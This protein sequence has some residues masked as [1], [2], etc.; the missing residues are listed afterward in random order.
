[1]ESTVLANAGIWKLL[2]RLN[3]QLTMRVGKKTIPGDAQLL[4]EEYSK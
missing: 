3:E 2:H 4:I 1:M